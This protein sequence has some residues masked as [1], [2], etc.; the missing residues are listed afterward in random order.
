[1]ASEMIEN[2]PFAEIREGQSAELQRTLTRDDIIMFSKLSGD[3]NPTHVDLDYARGTEGGV[4]TGHSLWSGGLLSSLMGNV[5]PGPGTIYRKQDL[6]FHRPVALDDTVTAR[7]RVREK[8]ADNLVVLDCDVSNQRG[9]TVATGVAEV[10]APSEKISV[11]KAQLP[12]V[13]VRHHD[14]YAALLKAAQG[15]EPIP[16]AVIHP[17]D[18]TSPTAPTPPCQSG[19][20]RHRDE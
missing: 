16:T 2:H 7:V 18:A 1:M 12:E 10:I 9:E 3:L 11:A 14:S 6:Q 13:S 4:V 19:T 17:C 8:G 20:W 5:L 15:Q